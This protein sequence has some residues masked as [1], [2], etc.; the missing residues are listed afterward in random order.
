MYDVATGRTFDGLETDG[1]I[2][3]NSG[4]ESTVHG[5]LSMLALDAHPGVKA[6]AYGSTRSLQQGWQ[7]VEAESGT[8]TQGKVVTPE[9]AWNGEASWSG[10]AYVTLSPGGQLG[11]EVTLPESG[12]YAVLPVF[13]QQPVLRFATGADI[14]LGGQPYTLWLGGAGKPGVSSNKGRL[15]VALA[16]APSTVPEAVPETVP[17][18]G[19]AEMNAVVPLSVSP[20]GKL[21][22]QLDAFLIRPEIARLDLTGTAEQT[23]LQSFAPERRVVTPQRVQERQSLYLR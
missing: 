5:L 6:A 14:T 16:S 1:R 19:T 8:L 13:E 2:N 15:T 3:P 18:T 11:L 21:P 4:A 23:L 10:G 9:S 22:V 20:T 12:R 7:L 17:E